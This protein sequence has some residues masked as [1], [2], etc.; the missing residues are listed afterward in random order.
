MAY[1]T[2]CPCAFYADR[3]LQS[4]VTAHSRL[5]ALPAGAAECRQNADT[6][7]STL[8]LQ[9][10]CM[11]WAHHLQS[12]VSTCFRRAADNSPLGRTAL[13]LDMLAIDCAPL[14]RDGG[15]NHVDVHCN[16]PAR[17]R[18]MDLINLLLGSAFTAYTNRG[19]AGCS[20]GSSLLQVMRDGCG[21][22][23]DRLNTVVQLQASRQFGCDSMTDS[24][25]LSPTRP[26]TLS[27]TGRPT[28]SPSLSPTPGPT[29]RPTTGPSPTPTPDPTLTPTPGPSASPTDR[30]TFICGDP[31][32]PDN[33][34]DCADR[35]TVN[36]SL[37]PWQ[38][39]CARFCANC[40]GSTQLAGAVSARVTAETE[41]E[42]VSTVVMR[43]AELSFDAVDVQGTGV[44]VKRAIDELLGA[45]T[46]RFELKRG[47]IICEFGLNRNSTAAQLARYGNFALFSDRI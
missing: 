42:I 12:A 15:Q 4:D 46:E 2:W 14:Y 33:L 11:V 7:R 23:A 21:E 38:D 32:L 17:E 6:D 3:C 18:T 25:T 34:T 19:Q 24:P 40:D 41:V 16:D 35:N 31:G 36:C 26:P 28:Y 1:S 43:F 44:A 37:Q 22:V 13:N 20:A 45:E 27:P 8:R 30:R 10:D 29:T 9:G 39:R 47:S 5:Q